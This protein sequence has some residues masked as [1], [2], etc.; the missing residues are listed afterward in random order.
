MGG[1]GKK[2]SGG[3][4]E[5]KVPRKEMN[6]RRKWVQLE[7]TNE[8]S[9]KVRGGKRA[10]QRHEGKNYIN[11]YEPKERRKKLTRGSLKR[12]SRGNLSTDVGGCFYKK[13]SSSGGEKSLLQGLKAELQLKTRL[14]VRT[15]GL[16]KKHTGGLKSEE[17]EKTKEPTRTPRV[18]ENGEGTRSEGLRGKK[19]GW[20]NKRRL[21]YR[22]E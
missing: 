11:I 15:E 8:L 10:I 16:E 4:F 14:S 9:R 22:T 1:G 7:A 6:I 17:T 19:V 21:R 18:C 12:G 2:K 5:K 20:K 3:N 13:E